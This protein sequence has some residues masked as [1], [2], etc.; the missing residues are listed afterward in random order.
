MSEWKRVKLRDCVEEVDERTTENNQYDVISS[1][2][3]C[4]ILQKEYFNRSIASENNAG[5]KILKKNQMISFL[6][7]YL[8]FF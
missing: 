7:L 3:D 8:L 4:L 6:Y 5:Y 1:T 2:K